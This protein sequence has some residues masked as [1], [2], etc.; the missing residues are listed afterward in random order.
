MHLVVRALLNTYRSQFPN[1]IEDATLFE[2]FVNFIS[3]RRY[4]ADAAEPNDLIFPGDDPG[5]DG[6]FFIAGDALISTVDELNDFMS[7]RHRDVDVRIIVT[8]AKSGEAWVKRDINNFTIGILDFFSENPRLPLSDKLKE[9]HAVFLNL[10]NHMGRITMGRPTIEASYATTGNMPSDKEI[11]A[12]RATLEDQL[13]GAGYFSDVN[14]YL[15]DREKINALWQAAAGSVDVKIGTIGTA[16]FPTAPGVDASYVATVRAK[17]FIDKVL[18][19]ES[20]N[21]R[22]RIFD[23]NV[24]DYIGADNDVNQEIAATLGDEQRQKRFGVM[25]NGVTVISPDVRLQG[26]ELFLRDFQIING[27][28]TSNVL[29]E[30]RD[31]VGDD[32]SLVIKVVHA[33]E[34]DFLEDIVRSTN[35]QSKVQDEQFLATINSLKGIERYF[36]A[37]EDATDQKLY[38]E[39]RKNQYSGRSIAAIRIFDVKQLARCFGAMFLDRPDLA[40]RYPNRLTG[41]LKSSVFDPDNRERAYYTAALAYYRI[42]LLFSNQRIDQKYSNLKWHL[43]MAIKVYL[44][45]GSA[46]QLTSAKLDVFCD[47]ID[48][49]VRSNSEG[50]V[51]ILSGLCEAISGGEAVSRDQLR[52]QQL[53]ANMRDIAAQLGRSGA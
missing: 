25:N 12:A 9:A 39:R 50:D 45:S 30:Q 28:Q 38:F 18:T 29:Y 40:M 7:D 34:P 13:R 46:P 19:D 14:V 21:L 6:V 1:N 49:L 22:P 43:M 47:R 10:F 32:V 52:S 4:T 53:V 24:R 35:R 5:I 44:S 20:G 27:C 17:E 41:E 48:A 37:N 42:F 23:E 36:E 3:I 11:V 15:V 33:R 16:P 8:Q 31:K 51:S 2:A 26:T